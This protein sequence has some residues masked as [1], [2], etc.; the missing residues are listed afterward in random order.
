[1]AG[2]CISN[3]LLVNNDLSVSGGSEKANAV[4]NLGYLDNSGC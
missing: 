2:Y 1:L 4:L 3:R